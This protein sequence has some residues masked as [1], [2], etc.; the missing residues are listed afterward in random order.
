MDGLIDSGLCPLVNRNIV[1][2]VDIH[3]TLT[4]SRALAEGFPCV[5]SR[6]ARPYN[7]LGG[8]YYPSSPGTSTWCSPALGDAQP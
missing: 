6:T 2:T 3:C 5:L 7:K 4:V 1:I 8:S